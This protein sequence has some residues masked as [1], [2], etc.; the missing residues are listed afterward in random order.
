MTQPIT[1]HT[2]VNILDIRVSFAL[3]HVTQGITIKF[4]RNKLVQRF[5]L[6]QFFDSSELSRLKPKLGQLMS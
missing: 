3:K 6:V 5:Y 4:Q 1:R 2:Y